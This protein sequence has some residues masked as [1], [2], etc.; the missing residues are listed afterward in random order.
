MNIHTNS[1]NDFIERYATRTAK[2]AHEAIDKHEAFVK[3]AAARTGEFHFTFRHAEETPKE[4]TISVE[5]IVGRWQFHS[6]DLPGM[7]LRKDED[8]SNYYFELQEDGKATAC[9][10][11]TTIDTTYHLK[12]DCISF[13]HAVLAAMK[14]TLDEDRLCMKGYLGMTVYFVKQERTE[15]DG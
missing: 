7:G 10:H 9:I 13:E 5:Q 4:N 1:S 12:K 3:Q 15:N 2:L 14:L 6:L 11:G 8:C